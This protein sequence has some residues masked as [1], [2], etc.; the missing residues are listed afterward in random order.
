[1]PPS[2]RSV[3]FASPCVFP[4]VLGLLYQYAIPSKRID[5]AYGGNKLTGAAYTQGLT[6]VT[7]GSCGPQPSLFNT[8]W[9]D[10]TPTTLPPDNTGAPDAPPNTSADTANVH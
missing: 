2:V 10:T 8:L 7:S 9:R 1:M 5:R 4:E 3:A 6:E